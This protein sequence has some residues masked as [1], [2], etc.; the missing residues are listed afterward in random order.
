MTLSHVIHGLIGRARGR[1][2]A[3]DV[4]E[5]LTSLAVLEEDDE[6]SLRLLAGRG[7]TL[8][9]AFTGIGQGKGMIQKEEFVGIGSGGGENHVIFVTDRLRSWF[10]RPGLQDRVIA[11]IGDYVA[12]HGIDRVVTIG[13][14]MGGFGALLFAE[15]L[16]AH[17]AIA[18]V[19]QFTMDPNVLAE[20]RWAKYRAN[21]DAAGLERLDNVLTGKVPAFAVFGADEGEDM[22]H[23]MALAA[24]PKVQLWKMTGAGHDVAAALKEETLLN[25]AVSAM[26]DL[27]LT[28]LRA[29]FGPRGTLVAQAPAEGR[30]KLKKGE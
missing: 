2:A 30:E 13:N 23:L 9:V 27:D 3:A 6:L 5:A 4:P 25:K 20:P 16:N 18:F 19:P 15:R 11:A 10:S 26:V 21:M 29:L 7:R 17:V 28:G 8:I 12:A 14:S 22:A 24:C 1:R